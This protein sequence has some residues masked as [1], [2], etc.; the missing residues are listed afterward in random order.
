MVTN[1][2]LELQN[3]RITLGQTLNHK[4]KTLTISRD[5]LFLLSPSTVSNVASGKDKGPDGQAVGMQF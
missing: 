3:P 5:F 1:S 2:N 4:S